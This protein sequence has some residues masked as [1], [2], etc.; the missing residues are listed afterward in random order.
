MPSKGAR[1]FDFRQESSAAWEVACPSARCASTRAKSASEYRFV[2]FCRRKGELGVGAGQSVFRFSHFTG[3]A[4]PSCSS[5]LSASK[6]RCAESR[7][8]PRFHQL[9]FEAQH[10][11]LVP[12][13]FAALRS[14]CAVRNWVSARAACA[15]SVDVIQNEKQLPLLDGVAFLDE[16]VPHAGRDRSVGLEVVD[17]LNFS[18][19]EKPGCGWC[20]AR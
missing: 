15:P 10:F 5:F 16:N 19:S 17:G 20:P 3:R 18:V 2:C 8:A 1:T 14:A 13:R 7:S 9:G 11:F 12:P 6:L 4:A